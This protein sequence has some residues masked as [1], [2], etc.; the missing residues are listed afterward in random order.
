MGALTVAI[1]RRTYPDGGKL[2][3]ADITGSSSYATNGETY[4]SAQFEMIT[5]SIDAML[6]CK[7]TPGYDL[8]FDIPN[9]KVKFFV[10]TT[11][12]EVANATNL[13]AVTGRVVVLGDAVGI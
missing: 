11:G 7:S 9:K 3:V 2:V 6:D 12:V 8:V 5:G 4:T 10:V 1:K 13:S